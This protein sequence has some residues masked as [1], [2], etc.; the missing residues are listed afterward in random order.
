M[1]YYAWVAVEKDANHHA[2]TTQAQLIDRIKAVFETLPRKS[3]ASAC[4][5]FRGRNEAVV[6]ANGRYFA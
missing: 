1:D 3:V 2:S 6:D 4:S 5:T